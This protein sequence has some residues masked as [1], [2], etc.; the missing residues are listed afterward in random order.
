MLGIQDLLKCAQDVSRVVGIGFDATCSLV[1]LDKTRQPLSV[2]KSGMC[3]RCV[4]LSYA[5]STRILDGRR[6][7]CAGHAA[8]NV[9]MWCDHRAQAQ[10]DRLG[11]SDSPAVARVVRGAGGHLSPELDVPKLMWLNEVLLRTYLTRH[12]HVPIS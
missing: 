10:A 7:H 12:A 4:L 11:R 5:D 9:I 8:R 6:V 3:L 2:S 1:L